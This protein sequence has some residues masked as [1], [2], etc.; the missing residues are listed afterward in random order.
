MSN[1]DGDNVNQRWY[2]RR[3]KV[4]SLL[5]LNP[6]LLYNDRSEQLHRVPMKYRVRLL[7]VWAGVASDKLQRKM[8]CLQCRKFFRAY[9]TH[10]QEVTCDKWPE[11][12]Y[13]RENQ[14]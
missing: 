7:K 13:Q 4:R 3:T 11:R 14:D 6:N 2:K 12:P 9:I 1:P 5:A 10:C 8:A